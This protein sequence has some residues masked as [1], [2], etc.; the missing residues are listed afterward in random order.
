MLTIFGLPKTSDKR[1]VSVDNDGTFIFINVCV[2]NEAIVPSFF[3]WHK[4]CGTAIIWVN[5][6]RAKKL[7]Y[8]F[9]DKHNITYTY[10]PRKQMLDVSKWNRIIIILI[11][12]VIF[13]VVLCFFVNYLYKHK[14][15]EPYEILCGHSFA[16][17]NE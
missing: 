5:C 10:R 16:Q 15:T 8:V 12:K 7:V 11:L 13:L 14:L 6:P 1:I 4:S 2:M 17:D 9:Y 3:C